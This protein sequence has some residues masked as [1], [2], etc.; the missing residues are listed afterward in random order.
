MD[1]C[2]WKVTINPFVSSPVLQ[3]LTC[4]TFNVQKRRCTQTVALSWVWKQIN[5]ARINHCVGCT[6]AGGAHPTTRGPQPTANFY[7]AV[8][9]CECW[10]NVHKPQ[11]INITMVASHS[12][13]WHS[14]LLNIIF[15]PKLWLLCSRRSQ[16]RRNYAMWKPLSVR[17]PGRSSPTPEADP[18]EK[19]E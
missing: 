16:W 5:S 3:S 1:E 14:V 18:A 8:L 17:L 4:L 6:M 9:A 7:H 10:E 15:P 2:L 19:I 13:Q 12:L 11:F